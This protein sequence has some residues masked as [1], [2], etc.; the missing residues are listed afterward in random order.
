MFTYSFPIP[1]ILRRLLTPLPL[2][3]V[4][5]LLGFIRIGI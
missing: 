5:F 1:Y 2:V 3:L 4:R